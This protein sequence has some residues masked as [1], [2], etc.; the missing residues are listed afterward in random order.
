MFGVPLDLTIL[1]FGVK[2]G[3]ISRLFISQD[4]RR[5][6]HR[7]HLFRLLLVFFF[8]R[9]VCSSGCFLS[10][11]CLYSTTGHLIC[12]YNFNEKCKLF[13]ICLFLLKYSDNLANIR[14]QRQSFSPFFRIICTISLNAGLWRSKKRLKFYAFLTCCASQLQLRYHFCIPSKA[15]AACLFWHHPAP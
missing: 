13:Q 8:D 9:S 7:Y 3:L 4:L 5:L 15:A 14:Y 12:Q 6:V 1:F 2:S 10:C 11:C